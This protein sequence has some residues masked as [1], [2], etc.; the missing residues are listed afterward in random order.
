MANEEQL[1]I[2]R[3]GVKA[4][5]TLREKNPHVRPD[6]SGAGRENLTARWRAVCHTCIICKTV[7]QYYAFYPA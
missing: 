7:G 4:W 1:R 2:L 6:L 5:N 3:R